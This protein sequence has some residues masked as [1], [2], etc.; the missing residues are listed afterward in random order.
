[1]TIQADSE[2]K[3]QNLFSNFRS[4]VILVI[5]ETRVKGDQIMYI[6]PKSDYLMEF[7]NVG[8]IKFAV[9]E[10]EGK[11]M[12]KF[13]LDTLINNQSEIL[14]RYL[15]R[16]YREHFI[17]RQVNSNRSILIYYISV[18]NYPTV[19]DLIKVHYESAENGELMQPSLFFQEACQF[20][21]E[22]A[23][24]NKFTMDDTQYFYNILKPH[25]DKYI[26]KF[27]ILMKF[28]EILKE[29]D[30]LSFEKT[31]NRPIRYHLIVLINY[32][33]YHTMILHE[34]KLVN[35]ALT[36]EKSFN[37]VFTCIERTS[38]LSIK[39]FRKSIDVWSMNNITFYPT[40]FETI[41]FFLLLYSPQYQLNY[42]T[43]SLY[44][45]DNYHDNLFI[46]RPKVRTQD[47]ETRLTLIK[48]LYQRIQETAE[49]NNISMGTYRQF[50]LLFGSTNHQP[51][52]MESLFLQSIED[53]SND[54]FLEYAE[55]IDQNIII[56]ADTSFAMSKEIDRD[57]NFINIEDFE[58]AIEFYMQTYQSRLT[59]EQ[60]K[61]FN[62]VFKEELQSIDQS[63]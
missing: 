31:W 38:Y 63:T 46:F 10:S 41:V 44:G 7:S 1:M 54:I 36:D 32:I 39:S 37:L 4:K 27:E 52:K 9:K 53:E 51:I 5:D 29:A 30:D 40:Y 12:L 42:Y 3:F 21:I 43:K 60:Q 26:H 59:P 62:K 56:N 6:I 23:I 57:I 55:I 8:T 48:Q 33:A 45:L 50:D 28:L 16:S 58:T 11:T 47:L 18:L 2:N 20:S 13:L 19:Q 34:E 35:F 49:Y 14:D 24:D 22:R 15:G 61:I 25:I 17:G